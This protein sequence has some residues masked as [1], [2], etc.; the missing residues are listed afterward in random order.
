M[1]Q[2][3]NGASGDT[4]SGGTVHTLRMTTAPATA[5][6]VRRISYFACLSESEAARFAAEL[7]PKSYAAREQ[8]ITIGE[9]TP[10]FFCLRSGKARIF[11]T[12]S[13]GREQTMRLVAP[14][15]T[16]GEVPV[17]DGSPAPASVEALEPCEVLLVPSMAFFAL[18]ERCPEVSFV[19][20]RHLARRLRGF[21]ELIEQI[22]LQSVPARLARYLYQLAREEGQS[23][24]EGIVVPRELTQ[25]DLA[26]VVG[27][28]R[29]VVSRTL[30]VMEDDGVVEVRRK[31]ILIR[32]LD[33][34]QR[35]V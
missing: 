31:E 15:D 16:F 12:G 20:L 23:T 34:L 26:S 18:V 5:A 1:L 10:G 35:M 17:F 24:K 28:V 30:R 22:S 7:V 2:A 8:V 19:M 4:F 11:R 29:E 25:Q 33:A 21:T 6:E 9:R 32:D 14:G 13:D 27:S 3:G